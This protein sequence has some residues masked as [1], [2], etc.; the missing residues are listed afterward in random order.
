MRIIGREDLLGQED[1]CCMDALFTRKTNTKVIDLISEAMATKTIDEWMRIFKEHDVPCERGY[2]PDEMLEDEQAWANDYL[3][4]IK[5]P[6]GN[7]RVVTT[8]PVQFRS[9]GNPDMV[10]SKPLGYHTSQ[11][12]KQFGYSDEDITRMKEEKAIM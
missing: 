6:S 1:I 8:S 5:Y 3:R 11:I 10:P 7:E 2:T 4:K 9:M 12:L